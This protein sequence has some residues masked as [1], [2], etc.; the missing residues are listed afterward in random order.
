MGCNLDYQITI[1][2]SHTSDL[3]HVYLCLKSILKEKKKIDIEIDC[4][5]IK[6]INNINWKKFLVTCQHSNIKETIIQKKIFGYNSCL[7]RSSESGYQ[8]DYYDLNHFQLI[9]SNID[10]EYVKLYA[11]NLQNEMGFQ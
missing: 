10:K 9:L 1:E 11:E 8:K 3:R 4:L 2:T 5:L 6:P 7:F